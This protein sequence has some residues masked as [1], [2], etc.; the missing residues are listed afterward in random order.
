MGKAGIIQVFFVIFWSY[1]SWS[2]DYKRISIDDGL[3]NSV[4]FSISQD[5]NGLI[6]IGTRSGIDSFDGSQFKHY[7]LMTDSTSLP[8][9]TRDILFDASNNLWIGTTNGLFRRN[10]EN[11]IFEP[12]LNESLKLQ[13]HKIFKL[14]SD[15]KNNLWIG[16]LNSLYVYKPELDSLIQI[17]EITIPVNDILCYNENFIIVATIRGVFKIN[18]SDYKATPISS[19]KNIN[20]TFS[21]EFIS[22]LQNDAN[23]K[24]LI[25]VLHK[26]LFIYDP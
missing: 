23:G 15:S 2:I 10:S 24:I 22:T 14:Q 6:W 20:D 12:A 5:Q 17:R 18:S 26:G 1:A 13:N 21:N 8:A 9:Q 19:K 11:G 3:S 25:G 7:D 16:T 4:V